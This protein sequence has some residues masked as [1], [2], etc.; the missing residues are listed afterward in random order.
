MANF[1]TFEDKADIESFD[2]PLDTDVKLLQYGGDG[3]RNRLDVALL[4]SPLNAITLTVSSEALA[5]ASTAFTV[6][7]T[8]KGA[9]G[10]VGAF[11][12]GSGRTQNYV[13]SN[14]KLKV[15]GTPARNTGYSVDLLANL[16][17]SGKSDQIKLYSKIILGPAGKDNLL[18]Q[19]P[20][21][22][23]L[24]CGDVAASYGKKLFGKDS[25]KEW[26]AFYKPPKN[27]VRADLRFDKR[28][29]EL[30]IS[31]IQTLL[32]SGIAVRVWVVDGDGFS[33]PQIQSNASNTHFLT[34]IGF[35]RNKFMYIDPWPGGSNMEYEG[36]MYDK[37]VVNFIGELIYDPMD[38][39]KGI[40]SPDKVGGIMQYTVVAGPQ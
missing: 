13:G 28:Q 18:S 40:K 16:A 3:S 15:G 9:T 25:S 14:L 11:V 33:F 17:M 35:A 36:G 27:G 32:N 38:L 31:R 34:I 2:L 37:R 4:N 1:Q 21:A 7:G 26:I 20:D 30:K 22:P 19:D 24:D 23:V 29:V 12:A 6:R 10:E 8:K 39:E 5:A